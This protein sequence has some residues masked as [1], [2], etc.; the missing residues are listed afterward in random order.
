M[1]QQLK[2]NELRLQR[3]ES[4][5]VEFLNLN[6][7]AQTIGNI[8]IEAKDEKEVLQLT[9]NALCIFT[10]WSFGHVFLEDT[11]QRGIF[12]CSSVHYVKYHDLYGEA[13]ERVLSNV[14]DESSPIIQQMGK[15]PIPLISRSFEPDAH[16]DV[17]AAFK[18]FV[19]LIS[20]GKLFGFFELVATEGD[21]P[22]QYL[23][24]VFHQIGHRIG[25]V[26]DVFSATEELSKFQ[27]AVQH[28][29]DHI[30]ITDSDAFI[31]YANK[32][33][34]KTTGY[35]R[36]ELIGQRPSLW[37]RQM[38]KAFYDNMWETIKIHK[39]PFRGEV[40]NIRK[41]GSP[42]T[43]E[44]HIS[45]IVGKNGDVEFFVGIERDITKE[46]EIDRMKTEFVSV[47]SHQLR[48]PLTGIKLLIEALIDE[49]GEKLNLQQKGYIE[50]I[51][52][53]VERMS[54]LVNDFLNVS[55][56][57]TGRLKIELKPTLLED[58]I[59]DIIDDVYQLARE[60]KCTIIFKKPK[61]KLPGISIDPALMRQ[62][63]HNLITNA[64][65]YSPT[66]KGEVLV[67]LEQKNNNY[68]I[69]IKD[70][71]IGIPK[72]V[73]QRIFG[74]FFRAD[75]AKEM[76]HE[77]SGLGLYIS[78]IIIEAFGDKIWFESEE[79]KGTTFFITIPL[80]KTV[81]KEKKSN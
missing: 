60:H 49:E 65:R 45:P 51:G 36:E 66:E 23:M 28:S 56:L 58:F 34:E 21:E 52:Q 50:E 18:V 77:G 62:V 46:K 31:L 32:A 76:Q 81:T 22:D 17:N 41:D 2:R 72:D 78:K 38:S 57:E 27:L 15:H 12:R 69:S 64:I 48:S 14:Y 55:Q 26:L 8:A 1:A 11:T 70:N 5:S 59:K 44:L 33:T 7:L 13:H 16:I 24:R 71:G 19:P 75:N 61:V 6:R 74:K 42:Y 35:S 10:G 80:A 9:I 20:M 79:N 63:I 73:Q 25:S 68:L 40:N 53:S 39:Q 54:R 67:Q 4:G 37:G 3:N 43:A 30:I 47:A 29:S